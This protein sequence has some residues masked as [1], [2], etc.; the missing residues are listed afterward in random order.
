M[1]FHANKFEVSVYSYESPD[2]N[3]HS[4]DV[5]RTF[6][7]NKHFASNR[8]SEMKDKLQ[9]VL[10]AFAADNPE[11]GYCQGLNI[12]A[13]VILLVV[14]DEV[15]TFHLLQFL[16]DKRIAAGYYKPDMYELKRDCQVLSS[17]VKWVAHTMF[18]FYV[19]WWKLIPESRLNASISWLF[20]SRQECRSATERAVDRWLSYKELGFL[21]PFSVS[22]QKIR[23]EKSKKWPKWER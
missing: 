11:I 18:K 2:E 10:R 14:N 12:V 19:L 9:K 1:Q 23:Y 22:F 20:I 6:P 3:F 15:A 17:L 7:E 13:A 16:I 5:P 8:P 4:T 21:F